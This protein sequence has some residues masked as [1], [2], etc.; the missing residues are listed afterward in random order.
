MRLTRAG[1]ETPLFLTNAQ[2]LGM[3]SGM[4]IL[5]GATLLLPTKWIGRYLSFAGTYQVCVT[6]SQAAELPHVAQ[7][8]A[9]DRLPVT[10]HSLESFSCPLPQEREPSEAR[11][12]PL[13]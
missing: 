4:L 1:Q 5:N 13:V 9:N 12:L 8:L 10:S 11:P 2:L 3:V 7:S 6:H